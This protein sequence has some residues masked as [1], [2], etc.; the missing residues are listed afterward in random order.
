MNRNPFQH[1]DIRVTDMQA[2]LPFYSKLLPA[3]GFVR[4]D[5]YATFFDDP[6]GNRLEIC[7]V[8]G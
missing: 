6:C 1:V 7:Y 4:A 3:V 2:A 5:S 8:A